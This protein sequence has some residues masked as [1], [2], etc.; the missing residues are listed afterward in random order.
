MGYESEKSWV[1]V[2]TRRINDYKVIENERFRSLFSNE[3]VSRGKIIFVKKK[4]CRGGNGET[5]FGKRRML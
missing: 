1:R 3:R 2:V 5:I 4:E